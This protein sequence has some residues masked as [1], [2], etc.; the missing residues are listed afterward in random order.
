MRP[1]NILRLLLGSLA[2]LFLLITGISLF[3]PSRVRIS[4]A[5]NVLAPDSL[6]RAPIADMRRWP[7]WNSLLDSAGTSDIR[8][9]Y[10]ET[11]YPYQL[12]LNE[13]KVTWLVRTDS[14]YL[15]EFQNSTGR[16]VT[17]GW[18]IIGHPRTDSVTVQWYLDF[19]LRWYPWEKFSSMLLEKTYGPRLE[20]G[21][22][23]LRR[24]MVSADR[25]IH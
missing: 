3:F 20:S 12:D 1:M 13:T 23:R 22:G 16:P 7:E 24:A 6:V 19:R 2:V 10:N 11:G 18:Q 4:R 25:P 21:L 5:I 8:Y 15:A 17:S 9:Q 14:L